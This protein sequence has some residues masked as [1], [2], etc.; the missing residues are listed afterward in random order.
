MLLCQIAYTKLSR[1][2][3]QVLQGRTS[4]LCRFEDRRLWVRIPGQLAINQPRQRPDQ[5]QLRTWGEFTRLLNDLGN[6]CCHCSLPF[7]RR[8]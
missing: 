2:C 6:L 1:R 5:L 3:E 7:A 8:A 4:R